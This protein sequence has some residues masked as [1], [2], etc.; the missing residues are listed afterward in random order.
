MF[1]NTTYDRDLTSWKMSRNSWPLR[2]VSPSFLKAW[3]FAFLSGDAGV[4]VLI[5]I[6]ML[7]ESVLRIVICVANLVQSPLSRANGSSN[8][9]SRTELLPLVKVLVE[10]LTYHEPIVTLIGLLPPPTVGYPVSRALTAENRSTHLRK[11]DEI[12]NTQVTQFVD[13]I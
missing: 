2:D 13:Y 12:S 10:I 5:E 9:A 8:S 4:A 1:E 7:S 3:S 6:V 11:G